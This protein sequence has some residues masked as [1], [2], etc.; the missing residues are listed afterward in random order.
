MGDA[1]A[2][3]DWKHFVVRSLGQG[4]RHFKLNTG[5]DMGENTHKSWL[6]VEV[7]EKEMVVGVA[8]EGRRD[9]KR[10]KERE[11]ER[12]GGAGRQTDRHQAG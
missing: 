8:G 11:R 5:R 6:V 10:E 3:I 2:V 12:G 9:G 4:D 7:K 1:V